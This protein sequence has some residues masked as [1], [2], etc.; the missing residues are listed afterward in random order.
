MRPQSPNVDVRWQ[1]GE[2]LISNI[3]MHI[4][5]LGSENRVTIAHSMEENMLA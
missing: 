2:I 5:I 1:V 4:L 3:Q